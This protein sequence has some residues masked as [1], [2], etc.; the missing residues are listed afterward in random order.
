MDASATKF[1]HYVLPVLPG[2]A[3]LIA[4]FIDRLWEEG[5]GARTRCRCCSALVLFFLVGKDLATTPRT[6]PTSSSTTTTAPTRTSWTAGRVVFGWSRRP[7]MSG[8][9]VAAVLLA[10]GRSG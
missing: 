10:R 2:L 4:L 5:L 7:L 1:H 9:L 3:I 6:S 8:D